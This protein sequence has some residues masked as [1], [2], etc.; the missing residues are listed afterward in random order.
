MS[1]IFSNTN[2]KLK[3]KNYLIAEIEQYNNLNEPLTLNIVLIG[4]NLSSIKYVNLKKKIGAEIGI[5]V[6]I[7][8][9]D[10]TEID[11]H[12]KIQSLLKEVNW[13]NYNSNSNSNSNSNTPEILQSNL[14]SIT[15]P[16]TEK[17]AAFQGIIFQLPLAEEFLKYIDQ[18]PVF[19]D[20]DLLSNNWPTLLNNNIL[21]PT[22]SAIQLCLYEMLTIQN[23][24][25]KTNNSEKILNLKGKTVAVIGQG[26]LVGSPTLNWLAKT[27]ATII[28]INKDT[29]EPKKLTKQA[30]ILI[31][32]VGVPNLVNSSWLKTNSIIIDAGTS[33]V[34]GSLIGDVNKNDLPEKCI[35]CPSPGGI[36]PLTVLCLFQ[37]LLELGKL[38]H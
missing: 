36:G 10:G 11:I 1:T 3:L 5:K 29:I 15:K 32:G 21:W 20:V 4:E 18:V 37:N 17:R 38:R 25:F 34:Q 28:S 19:S 7:H 2:L 30:D 12:Q 8:K 26:K 9:F 16:N 23:K 24:E 14:P 35:L 22:V 13:S 33:D 6:I 31:T 27:E